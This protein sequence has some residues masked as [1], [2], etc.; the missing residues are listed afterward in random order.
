MDRRDFLKLFAITATGIYIPKTSYF[1]MPKQLTEFSYRNRKFLVPIYR[2]PAEAL[3]H[4]SGGFD[5]GLI[6]PQ[7]IEIDVIDELLGTRPIV[8]FQ[9]I[10]IKIDEMPKTKESLDAKLRKFMMEKLMK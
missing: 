6:M 8:T 10:E 5:G 2:G 9:T 7:E 1:F 3:F 4:P